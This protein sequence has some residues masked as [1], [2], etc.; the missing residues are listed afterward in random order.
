MQVVEVNWQLT[1]SDDNLGVLEG[2]IFV[3]RHISDGFLPWLLYW[4]IAVAPQ[5]DSLP[6]LCADD[7]VEIHALA[8]L[9]NDVH[10]DIYAVCVFTAQQRKKKSK[11]PLSH[12]SIYCETRTKRY[13]FKDAVKDVLP[14]REAPKNTSIRHECSLDLRAAVSLTEVSDVVF[15]LLSAVTTCL[16]N[17]EELY[18]Q[19]F[20]E[21][22]SWGHWLAFAVES[23][24]DWNSRRITILLIALFFSSLKREIYNYVK[25]SLPIKFLFA[26]YEVSGRVHDEKGCWMVVCGRRWPYRTFWVHARR[27]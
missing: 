13:N 17:L 10:T 22:R 20:H 12:Q 21:D 4:Q 8:L 26:K 27:R 3:N 7:G 19:W 2:R 11:S 5:Q 23:S 14:S 15:R 18:S 6:L 25:F 16:R 1:H 24:A 9:T